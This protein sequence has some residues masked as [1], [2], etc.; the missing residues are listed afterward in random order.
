MHLANNDTGQTKSDKKGLSSRQLKA[1]PY[2]IGADSE[3][4]ACEQANIARQTYYEWLKE[5]A[6]KAELGRLRDAV[7]E[8]AVE[9]LKAHTTKAVDTLVQL[10][11]VPNPSIR[12]NVA[13]DILQ[14]VIRLKEL[15][16]MRSELSF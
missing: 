13:N 2:L 16:E 4:E 15:Q 3:G 11:D 10:L 14:N 8:D 6:F 1:L 7:V 5:P 12:R 9:T